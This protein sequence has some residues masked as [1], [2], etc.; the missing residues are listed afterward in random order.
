MVFTFVGE[1]VH[2][3]VILGI[4]FIILVFPDFYSHVHFLFLAVVEREFLN[5][6]IFYGQKIPRFTYFEIF[7][8]GTSSEDFLSFWK[9]L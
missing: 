7:T 3:W 1:L 6:V 5:G 8:V 4:V 9:C 2:V